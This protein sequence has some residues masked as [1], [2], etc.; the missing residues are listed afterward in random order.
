VAA[1][2]G[3]LSL[4]SNEGLLA[5]STQLRLW[6]IVSAA[7]LAIAT[8]HVLF[9]D[10]AF[11]GQLIFAPR[12]AALLLR[13]FRRTIPLLLILS[14]PA[15]VLPA[16]GGLAVRDAVLLGMSSGA[17]VVG[18]WWLAVQ[19]YVRL[20]AVSQLWQ[21]GERGA[22]FERVG[23]RERM[24]VG[25][26]RGS[27]PVLGATSGLFVIGALAAVVWGALQSAGLAHGGWIAASLVVLAA[28][29]RQRAWLGRADHFVFRTQAFFDEMYR[30]FGGARESDR[31][32]LPFASLYWVP[33]RIRPAVWAQLRQMDRRMPVGR[34]M[35]AALLLVWMI[36]YGQGYGATVAAFLAFITFAKNSA[37]FMLS[38]PDASPPGLH[39][40]LHGP[41]S[42]AMVRAFV[43]LRWTLPWAIALGVAAL[44]ATTLTWSVVLAWI[45][46]DVALAIVS[47]VILAVNVEHSYRRRF[48]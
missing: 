36:I 41:A 23:L 43:S 10:R 16:A 24:P 25:M 32:P 46:V 17:G 15:L 3:S 26:P 4:A 37:P 30:A 21:E 6:W 44:F 19:T 22:W 47:G 40:R 48:A 5:V 34:V 42:W 13:E 2:Y 39:L 12:P 38:G 27:Y 20:G 45:A 9:P 7:I 28:A 29:A 33:R 14:I 11:A 31:E 35:A 8:P 1:I 18:L